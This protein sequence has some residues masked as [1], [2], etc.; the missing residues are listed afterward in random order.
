MANLAKRD[1]D[2]LELSGEKY[3][4]WKVEALTHLTANGLEGTI[5]KNNACT[6]REKAKA[7]AFL[8]LDK[9]RELQ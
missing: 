6:P 4:E 9:Q 5:E 7:I 8:R 2:I 1:F 3:F